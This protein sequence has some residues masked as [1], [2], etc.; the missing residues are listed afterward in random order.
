MSEPE[1]FF[2]LQQMILMYHCIDC[3]C[4]DDLDMNMARLVV[5]LD[6]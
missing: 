1:E 3:G 5:M 4:P 2:S 6:D